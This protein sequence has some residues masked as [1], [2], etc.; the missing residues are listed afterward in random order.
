MSSTFRPS[1]P[2]KHTIVEE[3]SS[4]KGTLTSTCPIH[5]HGRIEGELET[6]ALT[7][8]ATG[9]VHG[10]AK[11]GEVR[12]QGELSGEFEADTIELAGT[13]RD[14]T[15]IRARSLEVKLSSTRGKLQ[16][17]FGECELAVGDAPTERDAVETPSTLSDALLTVQ[18][19]QIA[20]EPPPAETAAEA[21]LAMPVAAPLAAPEAP[22]TASPAA[23]NEDLL[24]DDEEEDDGAPVEAAGGGK[25]RR[26]R[27]Q[28]DDPA[29][30]GWSQ[31]P[32]Q[33]PP[34]S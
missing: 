3:G 33:P 8:S 20:P 16:V 18:A 7:V 27:K 12:S 6:P 31:H 29:S 10:R 22:A 21:P 34:G 25:K 30:N 15:V 14:N 23:E 28:G 11:V 1:A 9:A 26:K 19:S 4:F 5:V 24:L 2:T 13:V 32:S 17:I